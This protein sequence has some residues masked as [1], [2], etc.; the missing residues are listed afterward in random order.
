MRHLC[1]P[2]LALVVLSQV[3]LGHSAEQPAKCKLKLVRIEPLLPG[4]PCPDD[5]LF[6]RGVSA[7][8]VGKKVLGNLHDEEWKEAERKSKEMEKGFRAIVRKEPNQYQ[9]EYPL[10]AVITLADRKYAFI[11]DKQSKQ[12]QGYDRCYFDLNGNGDLTDDIPIDVPKAYKTAESHRSRNGFVTTVYQFPRVEL[13]LHSEGTEWNYPLFLSSITTTRDKDLSVGATFFPAAYRQGEILLRGSK[14]TLVL[15]DW[16]TTGRFDV[17][18]SFASNGKGVHEF[19]DQ[20]GTEFLVDPKHLANPSITQHRQFL[21]KMN[22]LGGRFYNIKVTPGGDEL[23]CTPVE[24]P[25]GRITVPQPPCNVW[26]I[27]DDGFIALDLRDSAPVDVPVGKWRLL[28]YTL[29]RG[30]KTGQAS[31]TSKAGGKAACPKGSVSELPKSIWVYTDRVL[32][33]E[34]ITVVANQTTTM[35]IGPPYA[36][37][38]TVERKGKVA[39][40]GVQVRGI[41]QEKI[42]P[43]VTGITQSKPKI[44][45]TDPQG[46]LVEQ[47]SLE[48]G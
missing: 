31:A 13:T 29:W 8:F 1:W 41:G 33:C 22:A 18:V 44:R 47:G 45:I 6:V 9:A 19:L 42:H 15:I 24:V 38:L 32:D 40:L 25:M 37:T 10:R 39:T 2:L 23:T 36:P 46:N 5:E 34:P 35:K 43:W 26:L 4:K 7:Q 17:P 30:A 16:S 28:A 48:Y 14:H 12:S 3:E 11:L 21:G 20:I 27:N